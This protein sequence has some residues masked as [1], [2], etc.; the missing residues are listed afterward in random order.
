[1][2]ASV[3]TFLGSPEQSEGPR[4]HPGT[5]ESSNASAYS[6]SRNSSSIF[7]L[8]ISCRPSMHLA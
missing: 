7:R 4:T 5:Y 2:S 3:C 1:M 8:T 6:Y